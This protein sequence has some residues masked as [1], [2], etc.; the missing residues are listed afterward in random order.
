MNL[1]LFAGLEKIV[2]S[3]TSSELDSSRSTAVVS[4]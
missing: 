2:P 4:V 3:G 1:L